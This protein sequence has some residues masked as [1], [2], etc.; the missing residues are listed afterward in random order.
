MNNKFQTI[1][2]RANIKTIFNLSALFN[3]I[4]N[5]NGSIIMITLMVLVTITVI[6]LISSDSVVTEKFIIRNQAIY[7]QNLNMVDAALMEALQRFIDDLDPDDPDDFDVKAS[8]TDWLNDIDNN[9]WNNDP[10]SWYSSNLSNKLLNANNSDDI[11]TSQ[12]LADRGENL[13]GN[14]RVALVGWIDAVSNQGGTGGGSQSLAIGVSSG[15]A[16]EKSQC[17]DGRL[18]SEYVSTNSTYGVLRMEI[19]IRREFKKKTL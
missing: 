6:G 2:N 14:L 1:I 4:S 15:T 19:G 9:T 3:P 11:N 10:G 16:S 18:L 12:I 17:M 7:K 8:N 5:S 13:A